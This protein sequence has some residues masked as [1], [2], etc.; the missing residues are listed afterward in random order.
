MPKTTIDRLINRDYKNISVKNNWFYGYI[1]KTKASVQLLSDDAVSINIDGIFDG[2][3]YQIIEYRTTGVYVVSAIPKTEDESADFYFK[4][5]K[6]RSP[7]IICALPPNGDL[8]QAEVVPLNSLL[9]CLE[10]I[11]F[12]KQDSLHDSID[13]QL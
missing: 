12:N 10:S 7:V 3:K 8:K 5:I 6:L 13:I 2:I 1:D 11:K 4:S 9:S